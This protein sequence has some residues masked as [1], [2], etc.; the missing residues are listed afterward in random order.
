MELPLENLPADKFNVFVSVQKKI[1]QVLSEKREERRQ[2]QEKES[3]GV[4]GMGKYF[5]QPTFDDLKFDDREVEAWKQFKS[6][7][8]DETV[9]LLSA[10]VELGRNN[11]YFAQLEYYLDN[12]V[13]DKKT[14]GVDELGTRL[15]YNNNT[16]ELLYAGLKSC[17]QTTLLNI[18]KNNGL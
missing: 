3:D 14:F 18:L 15:F 2:R 16:M 11:Q 1:S 7:V 8:P 5:Y 6:E 4:D 10:L 17:G 13:A 12:V 9:V